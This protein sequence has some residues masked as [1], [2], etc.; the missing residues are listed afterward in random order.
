MLP[1]ILIDILLGLIVLTVWLN[2]AN[3]YLRILIS[4]TSNSIRTSLSN[5]TI[6]F[7]P[8]FIDLAL[9]QARSFPEIPNFA[10]IPI[11]SFATATGVFLVNLELE[12]KKQKREKLKIAKIL[13]CV[14][15]AQVE[16]ID[17]FQ[18]ALK[19]NKI[20]IEPGMYDLLGEILVNKEISA[21]ILNNAG[22]FPIEI[23]RDLMG[24]SD[25]L[26]KNLMSILLVNQEIKAENHSMF[27]VEKKNGELM[28]EMIQ[29]TVSKGAIAL[30]NIYENIMRDKER[31]EKYSK[32]I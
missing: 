10:T 17:S 6:I 19:E 1:H 30:Q 8:F 27:N 20:C 5:L 31:A 23:I 4:E 21:L 18:K 26:N 32:L 9:F 24:Y 12:S 13:V 7:I 2:I 25:Q 15:E 16:D 14:I 22:I 28:I 29:K 3:G 11:T